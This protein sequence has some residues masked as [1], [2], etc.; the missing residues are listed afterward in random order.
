MQGHYANE[1]DEDDNPHDDTTT[2]MSKK[3]GYNFMNQGQFSNIQEGGT[4]GNTMDEV[5]TVLTMS[6]G[7]PLFNMMLYAIYKTRQ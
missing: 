1:C 4:K 2:K 6:T 5:Q 7:L 3:K